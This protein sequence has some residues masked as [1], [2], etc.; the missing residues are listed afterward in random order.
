MCGRYTLH[1]DTEQVIRRFLLGRVSAPLAPRYNIAP[2]QHV[3]VVIGES[4]QR[5]L[6][7]MRWGLVPAWAKDLSIGNKLINARAETLAEKPAFKNAL[8]HRRCLIM[9]DGFY[10]WKKVAGGKM[11]IHIR[12]KDHQLFAF[13][14]L[15]DKWTSGETGEQVHSCTIITIEANELLKPIHDRMP[16]ILRPE[17]EAAWLDPHLH[18]PAALVPLLRPLPPEDLEIYPVSR[19]VNAPANDHPDCICPLVS[20]SP[21]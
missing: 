14:G 3:A 15:W 16:A 17:D 4:G 11:P 19:R 20:D 5:Q 12:R 8:K 13:A 18:D 6:V 2:T 9:A 21:A 1:A 10:E 7:T